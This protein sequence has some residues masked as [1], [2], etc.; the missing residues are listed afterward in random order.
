MVKFSY[1]FDLPC[2]FKFDRILVANYAA[3]KMITYIV[4]KRLFLSRTSCSRN[5]GI[6]TST[7]SSITGISSV[8][9][10]VRNVS[11]I[12]PLDLTNVSPNLKSRLESIIGIDLRPE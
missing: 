1:K 12:I 9:S 11:S 3:P 8:D 6:S 7:T 4:D 2:V 10:R 5:S